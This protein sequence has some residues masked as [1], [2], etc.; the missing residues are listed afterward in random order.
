MTQ[1]TIGAF[2]DKGVKQENEDSYGV[3]LPEELQTLTKG[4]AVA[5]ADGMSG[6]QAGKA[7]SETCVKSLLEDY[8]STPDSWSVKKSI[9]KILLATNRWMYGQGQSVYGSDLGMVSTLSALVVKSGS[10]YIFHIGDSRICLLRAGKIDQLTTDHR[11]GKGSALARAMGTGQ[12]LEIDYRIIE[13][14]RGDVFFLTTDGVHEFAGPVMMKQVVERHPDD[15]MKVAQEI[16]I[17]AL[18][19]G[20]DDNLT[21]QVIRIDDTGRENAFRARCHLSFPPELE[22]GML[23]DGY[24]IIRDLHANA[25][26]QVYLARDR[27]N[28]DLVALKTPSA[29]FN[30]DAHYIE[31]FHREEWVGR[32]VSSPHILKVLPFARDRSCLYYVTEYIAGQTLREWINDHPAPEMSMVRDI[33]RQLIQGVR[34]MHRQDMVH[35]DLKPENIMI[36]AAGTVKIIDFGSVKVASVEEGRDASQTRLPAGAVDYM[37]PEYLLY[38][39]GDRGGDLYSLGV[40]IYEMLTHKLPYG[41]GFANMRHV[42]H[43]DY[44]PASQ[45]NPDIPPWLDPVLQKAVLKDPRDRYQ[46]LSQFERDFTVPPPVQARVAFM[47]LL[48]KDPLT[49]WRALSGLLAFLLILAL[50]LR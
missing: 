1:I 37:A 13:V 29:N 36:D 22:P 44:I 6:C 33:L 28:G 3:M 39:D 34:A 30:D 43:L 35:Q 14:R 8:F 26:S 15:L 50:L 38:G 25:R 21:C 4:I 45:V 42:R 18:D 16:C 20:S 41:K 48:E 2:S 31:M 12:H 19:H 17:N 7:A 40:V 11:Y 49:F 10:A 5:V 9:S 23:L 27:G 24:E 47:P 32:Q 46:S